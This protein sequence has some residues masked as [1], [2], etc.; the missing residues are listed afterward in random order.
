M[1]N[2]KI[3]HILNFQTI[4]IAP[5]GELVY[6]VLAVFKTS[7]PQTDSAKIKFHTNRG[8]NC[9]GYRNDSETRRF[10]RKYHI[11]ICTFVLN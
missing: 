7:P 8:T 1:N 5:K 11:L 6:K 9:W 10:R 3:Y 4:R 2:W